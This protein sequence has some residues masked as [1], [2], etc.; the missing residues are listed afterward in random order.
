V[1][2]NENASGLVAKPVGFA[3]GVCEFHEFAS[4]A[5]RIDKAIKDP[6]T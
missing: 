2:A 4:Q 6:F 1:A 5:L 3:Q